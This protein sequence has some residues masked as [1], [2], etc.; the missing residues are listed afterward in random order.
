MVVSIGRAK[1][2]ADAANFSGTPVT[3]VGDAAF[4]AKPNALLEFVKGQNVVQMQPN[5]PLIDQDNVTRLEN[6]AKQAAGRA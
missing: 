6:L 5:T 4:L 2:D 1:Y 3:G